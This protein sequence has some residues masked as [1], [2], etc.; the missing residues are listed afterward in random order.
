MCCEIF[1][2]VVMVGGLPR[3]ILSESARI[4]QFLKIDLL[5]SMLDLIERNR[6][7]RLQFS[8]LKNIPRSFTLVQ[9][10]KRGM[11]IL[12]FPGREA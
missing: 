12:A 5:D 6:N 4:F 7:P 8:H 10:A 11:I 9:G 1:V 2:S 3:A